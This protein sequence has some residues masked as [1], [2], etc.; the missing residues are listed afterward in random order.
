MSFRDFRDLCRKSNDYLKLCISAK[1]T[2]TRRSSIENLGNDNEFCVD[3]DPSFWFVECFSY[4]KYRY[5]L[6][7]ANSFLFH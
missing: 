6:F 7:N 3:A 1:Y 4:L 5:P 2:D